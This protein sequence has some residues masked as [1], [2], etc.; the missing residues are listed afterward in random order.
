[1][2]IVPSSLHVWMCG[3]SGGAEWRVLAGGGG[4]INKFKQA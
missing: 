2:S 4:A 1:M 3:C